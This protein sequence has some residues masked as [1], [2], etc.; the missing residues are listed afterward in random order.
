MIPGPVLRMPPGGRGRIVIH[1]TTTDTLV[2]CAP[3][4]VKCID[5]DTVRVAPDATD[6]VDFVAAPTTTSLYRAAKFSGGKLVQRPEPL[7]LMGAIVVDSTDE[8]LTRE[9]LL[10]INTWLSSADTNSFVMMI[11]GRTW[12]YTE[13]LNL[14]VGDS[15]HWRLLNTSLTEHPMHLHGFYFRVDGRGNVERD[16]TFATADRELVVTELLQGYGTA[17]LAWAPTRPGNWLFHCH[18]A[19]HM[20]A[21]QQDALAGRT[22][23]DTVVAHDGADH[24]QR[25][26]GGLVMALRVSGEPRPVAA[27]NPRTRRVRLL[28]QEHPHLYQKDPGLGFVIDSGPSRPAAD[29]IELPGPTLTLIR[30]EPVEITVINRLKTPTTVHWHGIELESYYDGVAGWSGANQSVAP[31]IAPRDSFIVR[32][33]PPRSGTFM[34]HA[35]VSEARMLTSGLYGP[36]LVVDPRRARDPSVDHMLMFSV[37]GPDSTALVVLNGRTATDT[38]RLRANVA[39]RLR[40]A[41]ITAG[42]EIDAAL[43]RG[44]DTLSWR[45]VAKD[46][47]DLP[48]SRARPHPARLHFGTGQT[49]DVEVS[50]APGDYHLSVKSFN[51]F[52]VPIRVR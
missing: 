49:L 36:L 31:L 20:A 43:V 50:L 27:S 39:N 44:T 14:S 37:Y 23:P 41:N 9:P 26:M 47:A 4:R 33:T 5:R 8:V 46:G 13:R 34:Y 16:T 29:S 2:L 3:M 17:R 48:P 6:S 45:P 25:G 10:V 7:E 1:N 19:F 40:L 15:L 38:V 51:N 30:D 28:V 32:F 42:D 52:E 12:P 24:L 35:H 11:N 22:P 18:V 21:A